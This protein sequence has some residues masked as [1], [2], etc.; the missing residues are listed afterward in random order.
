MI[1]ITSNEIVTPFYRFVATNN[2]GC[3]R[4]QTKHYRGS[5]VT[6]ALCGSIVTRAPFSISA[7][8]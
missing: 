2:T 4:C 7:A 3:T 1:N 5:K 8:R 6:R